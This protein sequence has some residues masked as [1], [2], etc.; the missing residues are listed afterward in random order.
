MN[1][2]VLYFEALSPKWRG[3]NAIGYSLF[4]FLIGF[5]FSVTL[6]EEL[7]SSGYLPVTEMD[8]EIYIYGFS[9]FIGFVLCAG[10][11]AS[12]LFIG[13]LT[14]IIGIGWLNKGVPRSEHYLSIFVVCML[15]YVLLAMCILTLTMGVT[16]A[17][18]FNGKLLQ[19][20]TSIA[21][22]GLVV[23]MVSILGQVLGIRLRQSLVAFCLAIML[24][25]FIG[26]V[27]IWFR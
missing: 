22:T 23:Y 27:M 17:G 15:E 19:I 25:I 18:F 5:F 11:V 24:V 4:V 1:P 10:L 20:N 7:S 21:L 16:K 6:L 8:T 13:Y 9:M 2:R 26:F 12:T 14:R 3:L